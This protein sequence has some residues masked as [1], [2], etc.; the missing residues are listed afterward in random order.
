MKTINTI[1]VKENYD[2]ENESEEELRE[3]NKNIQI[4]IKKNKILFR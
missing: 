4:I 1:S 2:S 3:K